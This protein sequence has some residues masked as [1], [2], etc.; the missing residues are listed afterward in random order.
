MLAGWL[1]TQGRAQAKYVKESLSS[2]YAKKSWGTP[3]AIGTGSF[4]G[5]FGVCMAIAIGIA[6]IAYSPAPDE[7]AAE[8]RPLIL[9]EWE[10]RGLSGATIENVSLE[11]K[12]GNVYTGFVDA[13]LGGQPERLSVEVTVARGAIKWELKPLRE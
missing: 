8:M 4:V 1:F 10:K 13:T 9:Q 3:L 2:G 6:V 7:L 12:H 5:Y 11:R